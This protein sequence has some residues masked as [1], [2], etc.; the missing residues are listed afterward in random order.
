M[1]EIFAALW[2]FFRFGFRGFGGHI[3]LWLIQYTK[4]L[5]I[6]QVG[7]LSEKCE[8]LISSSSYLIV[9]NITYEKENRTIWIYI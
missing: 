3:K 2:G 9:I 6:G 1:T 5:G 4:F 8:L 7:E